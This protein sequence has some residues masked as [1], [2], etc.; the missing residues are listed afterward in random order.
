MVRLGVGSGE[1][2]EEGEWDCFIHSGWCAASGVLLRNTGSREWFVLEW[3]KRG[4][5]G[6][7]FIHNGWCAAGGVLLRNTGV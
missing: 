1:W 7:C 5:G 3:G 2:G 4:N 6:V